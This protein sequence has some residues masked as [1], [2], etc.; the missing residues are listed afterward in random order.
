MQTGMGYHDCYIMYLHIHDCERF[1]NE[2]L[3]KYGVFKLIEYS[4]LTL[5]ISPQHFITTLFI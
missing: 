4:I 2:P 3:S 5:E 1:F